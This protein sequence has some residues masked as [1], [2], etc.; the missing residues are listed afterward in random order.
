MNTVKDVLHDADPLRFEPGLS[1]EE[2]ARLCR[3]V[4]AAASE[5]EVRT[6]APV[7]R[8]RAVSAALVLMIVGA[9]VGSRMSWRDTGT[10]QAAVRF[11]V[12]LAETH[13]GAGLREARIAASNEV[14]YLHPEV[15]VTNDDISGSRIVEKSDPSHF[16]ILVT[17]N[18]AGAGKMRRAT[19]EH[20]GAPV[21]ILIYGEVVAAPTVRSP[22][23]SSAVISG[24]YT[25]A[26][27]ERIANGMRVR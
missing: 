23:D 25:R 27:A 5:R 12:H 4:L 22:I 15:V 8:W 14:V 2:R 6:A 18:A 21:A 11:E 17:F 16:E 1:N 7:R 3:T 19:A 24:D 13:P 9:A 10:L 20:I 26:E